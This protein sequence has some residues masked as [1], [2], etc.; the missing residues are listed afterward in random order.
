MRTTGTS[1][2]RFPPP[3]IRVRLTQCQSPSPNRC[4]WS[5]PAQSRDTYL[6]ESPVVS[7]VTLAPAWADVP[8]ASQ[9]HC[10]SCAVNAGSCAR[11]AP[12]AH[13]ARPWVAF[14]QGALGPVP[15]RLVFAFAFIAS[16]KRNKAAATT[17][18]TGDGVGGEG[19]RARPPGPRAHRRGK[20]SPGRSRAPPCG[21]GAKLKIHAGSGGP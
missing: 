18:T 3:R 21:A 16:L 11:T 13:S 10:W 8:G 1:R 12:P 17:A 6:L 15:P 7:R 19:R 4:H 9:Q 20:R 5:S 2:F 14:A